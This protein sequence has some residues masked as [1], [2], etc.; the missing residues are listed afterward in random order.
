MRALVD[1]APQAEAWVERRMAGLR[2]YLTFLYASR[3]RLA[4][5]AVVLFSGWLFV[6]VMFGANGMEVYRRKRGEY[7]DLQKQIETL[8]RENDRYT[9]QI[10]SLQTDPATIEKEAREQFGYTRKGEVVYVTPA[11]PAS[12]SPANATARK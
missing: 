6:H 9:I 3:R 1:R 11:L 4:T 7:Q 5:A 10:K 12:Q 8:Q 2:P